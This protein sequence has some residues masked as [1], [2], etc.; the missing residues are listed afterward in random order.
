MQLPGRSTTM[1]RDSINQSAVF[2]TGDFQHMPCCR[3]RDKGGPPGVI[4]RPILVFL[5][6][7]RNPHPLLRPFPAAS[8]CSIRR[9]VAGPVNLAWQAEHWCQNWHVDGELDW[10]RGSKGRFLADVR[11]CQTNT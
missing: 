9:Q 2:D 6:T 4:V 10:C 1:N 8:L 7:L 11:A 3:E 5:P